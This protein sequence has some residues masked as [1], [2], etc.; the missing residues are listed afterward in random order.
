MIKF[1]AARLHFKSD[2]FVAV[3]V[4]VSGEFTQQDSRKEGTAKRLCQGVTWLSVACFVMIF[5]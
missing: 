2:V 3:A 5:T 1:E 4:V